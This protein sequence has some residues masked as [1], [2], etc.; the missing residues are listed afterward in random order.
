[1]NGNDIPLLCDFDAADDPFDGFGGWV[2]RL[3]FIER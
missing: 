3:D 1:M 2:R